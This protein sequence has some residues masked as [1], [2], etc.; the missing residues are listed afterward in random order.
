MAN[1]Q[2]TPE[3]MLEEWDKIIQKAKPGAKAAADA[4]A[5]Y[6]VWYIQEIK[7]RQ[8]LHP[9]G[10]YNIQKGGE[11]PSYGSG[12]LARAMYMRSAHVGVRATALIGNKASYSRISE[13]GCVVD[14]NGD[15]MSWA[16]S[17]GKWYHK[18]LLHMPHPFMEPATQD[19]IDD[20][21]LQEEAVKA[22][23]EFD[24]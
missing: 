13:F 17:G 19:A 5:R 2:V 23:I 24:P 4:M 8:T 14:A 6:M 11:P 20:G 10:A 18:Q 15:Y 1:R 12:T 7:L 16:D 9:P 22:F 3:Q 21:S